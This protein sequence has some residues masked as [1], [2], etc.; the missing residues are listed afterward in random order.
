MNGLHDGWLG[1]AAECVNNLSLANLSSTEKRVIRHAK[2]VFFEHLLRKVL[3][4]T[5]RGRHRL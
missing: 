5:E 4:Q 3:V 2:P 1:N